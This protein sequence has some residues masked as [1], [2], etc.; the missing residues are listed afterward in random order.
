MDFDFST[1]PGGVTGGGG[2]GALTHGDT[3][4]LNV[5]DFGL[6][7][8]AFGADPEMVMF[9][10]VDNQV[11]YSSLV[12]GNAVPVGGGNP[13]SANAGGLV[14]IAESSSVAR[15]QFDTKRYYCP[16]GDANDGDLGEP[17]TWGP[18]NLHS[19]GIY[20]SWFDNIEGTLT[21]SESSKFIRIW[22]DP[23]NPDK[24]ASYTNDK[25]DTVLDGNYPSSPVPD[26]QIWPDDPIPTNAWVRRE[27][28]IDRR[29]PAATVFRA[30]N[31]GAILTQ[32]SQTTITADCSALGNPYIANIGLDAGGTPSYPKF[33]Y[34]D[35]YMSEHCNRIE[36]TDHATWGSETHAELQEV[37]SW[38][39]NNVQVRLFQG[40]FES[41]DGLFYHF[42]DNNNAAVASVALSSL[43][44]D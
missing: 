30:W 1:F 15:H 41:L 2:G 6:S 32:G 23:S 8:G 18:G 22:G 37:L 27:I 11:A 39:S 24:Y 3:I 20:V 28:W 25:L 31:D 26:G 40:A 17:A 19:D 44:P 16:A 35:I 21:A 43:S 9:D 13:W 36:L 12:D 4:T 10:T 34:T 7:A 42:I 29:V 5:S 14:K 33:S 38:D